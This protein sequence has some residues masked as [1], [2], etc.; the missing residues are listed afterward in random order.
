MF[1]AICGTVVKKNNEARGSF[2]R[3][4]GPLGPFLRLR[5]PEIFGT[6]MC[7]RTAGFYHVLS[8]SV[9]PSVSVESHGASNDVLHEV[10][11]RFVFERYVAV[12][13]PSFLASSPTVTP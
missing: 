5:G 9:V 6:G 4:L 11:L 13:R 10:F 12:W 3:F 1:S 7:D 2:S 8:V